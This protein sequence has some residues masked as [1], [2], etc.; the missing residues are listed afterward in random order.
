MTPPVLTVSGLSKRYSHSLSRGLA[1]A[2][3][4][5]GRELVPGAGTALR[6][7]EFWALDGIGLDLAAGEGLAIVGGN[8][9]GKSTLLK[10][11][12]GLLKPD[13]G[14]VVVRGRCHPIIELGAGLNPL[15]TGRENIRFGAALRGLRGRAVARLEEEAIDF[16]GIEEAIDSTVQSY[17]TGMKARLSYALAAQLRADLLL[18][19]E[20]LTV[21]DFAFQ[22]KCMSHMRT[23]LDEGGALLLV[24]HNAFQIQAV[25]ERGL[26]LDHGRPAF[27]GTAAETLNRMFDVTAEAEAEAEAAPAPAAAAGGESGA[28]QLVDIIAEGPDGGAAETGAPLH[29]RVRYRCEKPVEISWQFN[30]WTSDQ[31][32]CVTGAVSPGPMRLEAGEGE[33]VARIPR[34]PLLPGR[35][36]L[37]VA[38]LDPEGR[39]PLVA[40]GW[41]DGAVPVRVTGHPSA[42]S[43]V[44]AQLQ[45]LVATDVDWG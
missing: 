22:R 29:I 33:L 5:I 6:R 9:A 36:G 26:L 27:A 11:I 2:L 39:L 41:S 3:R 34:L 17:S 25:C 40:R 35:Y 32:V 20:V 38:L 28:L 14:R 4:D 1:Y 15:L 44:E 23:Y 45:Q 18:V 30:L 7:D 37:R 13:R 24:S 10:L 42:A 19:D 12:A 16:A 43:N 8:G 21:G 31:W